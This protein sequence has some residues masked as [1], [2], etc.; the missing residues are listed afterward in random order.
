MARRDISC[1]GT[2]VS[3]IGYGPR[4]ADALT[5]A[6]KR[7]PAGVSIEVID[8]RMVAVV[9]GDLAS[10]RPQSEIQSTVEV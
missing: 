1:V 5:V 6:E 9:S 10:R 2:D 8:Q 7:A 3:V 4:I